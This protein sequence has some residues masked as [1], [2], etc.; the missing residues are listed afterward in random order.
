MAHRELLLTVT[1]YRMTPAYASNSTRTW[2]VTEAELDA[3]MLERG[4][5]HLECGTYTRTDDT[6]CEWHA[7]IDIIGHL[8]HPRG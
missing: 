4:Y 2:Y 3:V 5:T 6:G 1:E 8:Y 7:V